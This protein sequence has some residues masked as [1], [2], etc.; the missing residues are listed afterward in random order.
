LL[1]REEAP[2]PKAKAAADGNSWRTA[3]KMIH[4]DLLVAAQTPPLEAAQETK[5]DSATT[6]SMVQRNYLATV[7]PQRLLHSLLRSER[8]G[9]ATSWGDLLCLSIVLMNFGLW[10]LGQYY[11]HPQDSLSVIA[12]YRMEPGY[13]PLIHAFTHTTLG[14]TVLYESYGQGL[15][16]MPI[17]SLLPFGLMVAF[18]GPAGFIAA[19]LLLP[20]AFYYLARWFAVLLSGDMLIARL[21]ALLCTLRMHK[22]LETTT[23]F[24]FP[25]IWGIKIPRPFLAEIYVLAVLGLL[26]ALILQPDHLSRKR[27]LWLAVAI[28]LVAQSQFYFLLPSVAAACLVAWLTFLDNFRPW[29]SLRPILVTWWWSCLAGLLVVLPFIVQRACENDEIPARMGLIPMDWQ[30]MPGLLMFYGDNHENNAFLTF[31]LA[32]GILAIVAW[33]VEHHPDANRRRSYRRVCGLLFLWMGVAAIGPWLVVLLTHEMLL[34]H[35]FEKALIAICSYAFL[36]GLLMLFGLLQSRPIRPPWMAWTPASL[37][38]AIVLLFP[39]HLWHH[40]QVS[41]APHNGVWDTTFRDEGQVYRE[42]FSKLTRFLETRTAAGDKV[43]ASF[44]TQINA[45]WSCYGGGFVY[46]PDPT[47]S[48]ASNQRLEERVLE[49]ARMTGMSEA[50]FRQWVRDPYNIVYFLLLHRYAATKHFLA[51][52]PSDYHQE[53]LW[54]LSSPKTRYIEANLFAMPRSEEE[55]LTQALRALPDNLP[56]YRLDLLVCPRA[57][58]GQPASHRFERIYSNRL[59]Q[60]YRPR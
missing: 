45:W 44:D 33:W 17:P 43:I 30:S 31:A 6:R 14:E 50:G 48:L 21:F 35:H 53:D 15:R 55:R 47:N 34:M 25:L 46:A 9:W 8:S 51:S 36:A 38:L 37:G 4:R 59:F 58:A 2:E 12:I 39:A 11:Q 22:I 27:W 42:E 60:V 13:H 26:L 41:P 24:A 56:S 40:F 20:V 29:S 10:W 19:D 3:L 7:L 32:A 16:Y 5:M 23:G 1:A 57:I 52:N 49:V 28:G 18:L 54:R